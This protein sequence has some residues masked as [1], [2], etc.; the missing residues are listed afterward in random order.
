MRGLHTHLFGTPGGPEVLALHG[1]TG[2]GRRWESLGA[3]QLRDTRIVAPDLRGHG[4]SPWTPPWGFDTHVDDLVRVLDRHATGPV[5]VVAHSFGG[6]VAVHLARAVPE[7]IRGLVLLD[8]AIGLE[9]ELSG[10][11]AGLVAQFPDYTDAAEA[12]SEKVHGS[13]GDVPT[14]ALDADLAEH[15]IALPN[16]RVGWRMSIPAVVASW[17]E[18]A[19]GFVLPP[20]GLPTVLVQAQRVQPPYVTPA[21]RAALT[22]HLGPDLTVVDLDCDHMVPHAAPDEV[23]AL[24]RKLL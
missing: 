6:A 3:D 20:R 19:R 10:R 15:L 18:M 22:G 11:I 5:V 8:P 12:R 23:A 24:V 4:R 14:D 13:W 9:P 1:L 7:R 2:H 17:G 16:G 21:F